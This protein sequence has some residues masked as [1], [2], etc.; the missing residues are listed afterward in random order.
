LPAVSVSGAPENSQVLASA[1][2]SD[3]T[4]IATPDAPLGVAAESESSPAASVSNAPDEP[5][6]ATTKVS[7][8]LG[9]T[10]ET[11]TRLDIKPSTTLSINV[12][13]TTKLTAQ[14]CNTSFSKTFKFIAPRQRQTQKHQ[15]RQIQPKAIQQQQ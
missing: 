9:P 11:T 12:T 2:A 1:V 13:Q 4:T 6:N 5:N 15:P 14:L 3:A 7:P 8:F 10:N